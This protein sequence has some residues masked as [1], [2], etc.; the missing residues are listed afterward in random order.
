MNIVDFSHS[1]MS[2][3]PPLV[4]L[5]LAILTRRV[6]VS[7]GV[8]V[9]LGA[10]LLTDFSIGGTASYIGTTVTGLFH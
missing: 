7:L 1:A 5:G 10:F 6:L 2:L 3:L 8:G 9:L 4:A